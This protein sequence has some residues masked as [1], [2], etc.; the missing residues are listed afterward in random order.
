V[1]ATDTPAARAWL[2]ELPDEFTVF[3]WHGEMFS[4]PDGAELILGS[5]HCP[6]QAFVSGNTL[7]LQCHV[8]MMAPMV[9][10]WSALYAHEISSPGV[11]VQSAQEMTRDLDAR[12]AAAQAVADVLYRR[13]LAGLA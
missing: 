5:T 8:E 2:G 6:H 1:Q 10:E 4:V 9:P 13:W 7:A 12:I 3:H 11:T